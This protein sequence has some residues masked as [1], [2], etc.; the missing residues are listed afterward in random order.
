MGPLLRTA[1]YSTVQVI[2]DT[3]RKRRRAYAPFLIWMGN[4]RVTL[5]NTGVRVLPR[6]DWE[7]RE[8]RIYRS[9]YDLS[10]RIDADG[11]LILPCFAGKP[12]AAL[13]EAPDLKESIRKW[14]IERAVIAL[15][16]FH[17][18]GF[19]HGDARAENVMVNAGVARWF[20]FE[21]IHDSGR[22]AVWRRADDVRTFIASCLNR[23][24]P[25]KRAETLAF[26]VD[27]YADEEVARALA[28]LTGNRTSAETR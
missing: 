27:V 8:R 26:I 1:R 5:L 11:T 24:V 15:A 2:D 20:D 28:H 4:W 18:L 12:L 25:E 16:R 3:V 21:T 9:L 7:E 13:L 14:A 17:R 23:T 19:T 10:I 6:R 22:P